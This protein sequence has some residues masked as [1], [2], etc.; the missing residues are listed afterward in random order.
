MYVDSW[1][2]I[3]IKAAPQ[4]LTLKGKW[5]KDSQSVVNSCFRE[6]EGS[7]K[8]NLQL[9]EGN[10][11]RREDLSCSALNDKKLIRSPGDNASVALGIHSGDPGTKRAGLTWTAAA[12]TFANSRLPRTGPNKSHR[13]PSHL[14][15]LAPETMSTQAPLS[16]PP[17][18]VPQVASNEARK[19][20]NAS[21]NTL[22]ELVDENG[23]EERLAAHAESWD[24]C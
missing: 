12:M 2:R 15:I 11:T 20:E 1:T 17:R 19:V 5:Q 8:D 18:S 21:S 23:E 16:P 3:V 24:G 10:I 14:Y 9:R 4:R 7:G 13:P 22:E 6:R